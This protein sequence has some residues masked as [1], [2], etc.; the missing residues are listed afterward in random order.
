MVLGILL[1]AA[2]VLGSI[3]GFL[4][5]MP[6]NQIALQCAVMVAAAL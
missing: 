1:A 6:P 2:I 5:V 3:L 4:A